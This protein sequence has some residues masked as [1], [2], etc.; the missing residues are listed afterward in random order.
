MQKRLKIEE[1]GDF[2]RKKTIPVAR[3]KGQW[4]QAVG[5][6]PGRYLTLTVISQGC[7]E[8]RICGH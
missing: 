7:I 4:L 3:L 8:L 6:E 1:R 5:F 2:Y